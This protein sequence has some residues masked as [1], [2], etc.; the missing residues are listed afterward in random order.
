MIA[1]EMKK[2]FDEQG[3]VVAR[4]LFS[5][6]EITA[7]RDHYMDLRAK[8]SYPG[9]MVGVDPSSEDPLKRYPRM[10]HMHR[11]DETSMRFLIDARINEVLTALL[12]REPYAVQ[13]MIYFKPAGARGQAL[14]QDQFFLRARP[15]TCIAAWLALDLCDEKNGCMRVVP[16]SHRWPLLCPTHADTTISFTD[17]TVPLPQGQEVRP[18]IMNP[19]DV[20]FFGGSL[21]HGSFPNTSRDR[22]RRSLIGHYISG[23]AEQ[24]SRYMEP[25]Y[26]MDG[27]VATFHYSNEGG[28]CGVWVEKDGQ[29]VVEMSGA[30]SS[31]G[32]SE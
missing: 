32:G 10:I 22:F 12:G 14:H 3:Y 1:E 7:Y 17:L 8:G 27:T 28:P 5:S 13:T 20:L 4:Q 6:E 21:V 29:P 30:L 31:F 9:D 18:I 16:A 26:H 11:W 2:T 23:E 19:G 24:V 15:G 25:I